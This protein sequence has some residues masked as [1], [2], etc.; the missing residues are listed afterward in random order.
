MAADAEARADDAERARDEG[1]A[2]HERALREVRGRW[3]GMQWTV[4][5][6]NGMR[7]A[8]CEDALARRARL[9][10]CRA[11]AKGDGVRGGEISLS[12]RP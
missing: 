5:K 8:R 3:N 4:T 11:G 7:C 9:F 12:R 10:V 6:W 2:H 1:A